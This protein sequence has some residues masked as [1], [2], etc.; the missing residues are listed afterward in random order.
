VNT[1][2]IALILLIILIYSSTSIA[3][4]IEGNSVF[5]D[6]NQASLRVTPHT[7]QFPSAE[8][9]QQEFE[10]CNKTEVETTLYGAYLFDYNLL[11]AKAEYLTSKDYKWVE[12]EKDCF[13]DFDYN[14]SV[15]PA[16]NIHQGDCY[17]MA[18]DDKVI[19][20]SIAYKSFETPTIQYDVNE[21]VKNWNNVTS[22]FTE[23]EFANK[24][25]Y[26]YTNGKLVS[27]NTCET[28]RITYEPTENE[29]GKWDLWLWAN[30][31]GWDC[32]LTDGGSGC[33]KTLKLDPWWDGAG[34]EGDPFIITDC[35]QLQNIESYTTIQTVYFELGNDIDCS[36]FEN[37]EAIGAE[38]TDEFKGHIDGKNYSISNLEIEAS[39]GYGGTM[40]NII[41]DGGSVRNLALIDFNV[42]NTANG[43]SALVAKCYYCLLDNVYVQGGK[44][45][46]LG[47]Y[48]ASSLVSILNGDGNVSNCYTVDATIYA[49]G[50]GSVGGL[51]A[52]MGT[53]GHLFNSYSNA[54][55]YSGSSDVG[56]LVGLWGG[57]GI[58]CDD[59]FWDTTT[60]GYGSSACGTG[61]TTANM[62]KQASYTNW[63]FTNIW[64][65]EE[66]VSYPTLQSF[67][68]PNTAPTWTS[69]DLNESYSQENG[70][71]KMTAT[72][73][74]DTDTNPIT[75][76]C[77]TAT[78][79]TT[80]TNN[81][82]TAYAIASPYT[83]VECIGQGASG[84]AVNTIYCRLYDGTDYS[85]EKTDTYTA[86]NTAP[87]VSGA[88]MNESSNLIGVDYDLDI[89]ISDSGSGID[90]TPTYKC[91]SSG[92]SEEG[93][94]EASWDCKTGNLT[95]QGGDNYDAVIDGTLK[96]TSGT[97]NCK[98]YANDAVGLQGTDTDTETMNETTGYTVDTSTITYTG[99]QGSTENPALTD[100]TNAYIIF[101]HNGNTDLNLLNNCGDL[102]Y[103][104]YTI[105]KTNQKWLDSDNYAGSNTCTGYNQEIDATWSK[106]TY[107]TA[108][109]TN[110]YF[111]LDVPA[112]Q[113]LGNYTGTIVVGAT[114]SG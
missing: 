91:W 71:I 46:T 12:Y 110:V 70:N 75:L 11:Q 47:A 48:Y 62:F 77:G 60:S 89:V 37:W 44:F 38:T 39:S 66:D 92:S 34:S 88:E 106:G 13:F 2:W 104:A 36:A 105:P 73:S 103:S 49:N 6:G 10:I 64:E 52:F 20:F 111:W 101:T 94:T 31:T 22:S 17:Y 98:G 53:N 35:N 96:D 90:G 25:G 51:V 81:F 100:Q 41:A 50:A 18:G 76:L 63:D 9:Y 114:Q 27:G 97:W 16:P 3:Y 83:T 8:G 87:S 7:A 80:D 109:V 113:A 23:R 28:W 45:G 65:I 42:L 55:I 107:P 33:Q 93:C 29:E 112:G 72:G 78:E 69:I 102:T 21:L 108:T 4:T 61:L 79:P 74:T 82:C 30:D 99:S 84:D 68:P 59:S 54:T 40:F 19:D 26:I 5:L 15:N 43:A 14:E 32:I 57:E 1:R 24:T 67:I 56:G 86:D 85:T 95:D 58:T